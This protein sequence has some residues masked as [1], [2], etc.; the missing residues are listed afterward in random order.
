MADI[1]T[2]AGCVVTLFSLYKSYKNVQLTAIV[3]LLIGAICCII[4]GG[5]DSDEWCTTED[6]SSELYMNEC[7]AYLIFMYCLFTPLCIGYVILLILYRSQYSFT[8]LIFMRSKRIIYLM[9]ISSLMFIP[10]GIMMKWNFKDIDFEWQAYWV[11][12]VCFDIF[13]W[14]IA[15]VYGFSNSSNNDG[16]NKSDNNRIEK[17]FGI[18]HPL[19][20][21]PVTIIWII[22]FGSTLLWGLIGYT[23]YEY[24]TDD[25]LARYADY[26]LMVSVNLWIIGEVLS[27][28]EGYIDLENEIK[29][30][31]VQQIEEYTQNDDILL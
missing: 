23:Q 16:I 15:L 10:V 29:Y 2:I 22:A 13:T 26:I 6:A 27:E 25:L 18:Y 28:D 17:G 21:G 14:I 3:L 7:I 4:G 1:F 24:D 31:S 19:C 5:L 20:I 12:I 8:N 9:I 11:S 30:Q